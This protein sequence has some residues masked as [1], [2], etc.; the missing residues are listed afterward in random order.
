MDCKKIIKTIALILL[1]SVT[2]S[3]CTNQA[4]P[5]EKANSTNIE[6]LP[7]KQAEVSTLTKK[8]EIKR[9]Y[10]PTQDWKIS[11][12]EEQGMDSSTLDQLDKD[13]NKQ[14]PQIHSFLVVRH[15]YLVFEK[16]YSNQGEKLGKDDFHPLAS[17]TKTFTSSLIGI[18]MKEGYIKSVE[19][20]MADFFPEYIP[21]G[22]D[23]RLKDISLENLLTM[24]SGFAWSDMYMAQDWENSPNLIKHTFGLKI[25]NAPGEVFNYNSAASHILSGVVSAASM[26]KSKDFAQKYLFDPLGITNYSWPTDPQGNVGGSGGPRGLALRPRDMAKFGFLYLNEG[27]WDGKQILTSEWIK[28][29][30]LMHNS[31][32]WPHGESYGYL[33]WVTET[34]GY[35]AYFA[36]GMGGQFIY[37]VPDLDLVVAITSDWDS[38]HE[39]NRSLIAEHVIPA[40]KK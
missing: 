33:C 19:Q 27:N 38:H 36:G 34:K 1:I 32:G 9:D 40:I 26:M 35:S 20:K 25:S 8:T 30:T 4:K 12:P 28:Q 13:I 24:T 17:A 31:G 39:E 37:V 7:Q 5:R 15:G 22:Y 23:S 11:T 18:A 3:A 16:Y 14:F 29:S 6:D 2:T 21:A 10:W